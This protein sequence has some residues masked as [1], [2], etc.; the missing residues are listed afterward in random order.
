MFL[1][2]YV[3]IYI[4]VCIYIYIYMYIYI[5]TYIHMYIYVYIHIYGRE[6][7]DHTWLEKKKCKILTACGKIRKGAELTFSYRGMQVMQ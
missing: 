3:Y 7:V 6:Q 2:I 1:N 4:Y 5:Y